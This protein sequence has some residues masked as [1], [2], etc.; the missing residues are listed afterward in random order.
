MG[1]RSRCPLESAAQ[2]SPDKLGPTSISENNEMKP[3]ERP[4][5]LLRRNGS[6]C[7]EAE[8]KNCP[9]L[10]QQKWDSYV[11]AFGEAS[12][13]YVFLM[14]REPADVE[15]SKNFFA[16]RRHKSVFITLNDNLGPFVKESDI[17]FAGLL[18]NAAG[19]SAAVWELQ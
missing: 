1:V 4:S 16:R 3:F 6:L 19:V 8:P 9:D 14:L 13:D 17:D 5:M 7:S 10:Q 2:L 15:A 18:Q 11:A 12:A